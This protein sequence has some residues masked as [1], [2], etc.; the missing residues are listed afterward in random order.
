MRSTRNRGFPATASASISARCSGEA[1]CAAGL[2]GCARAGRKRTVTPKRSASVSAATRWP[3]CT[4]SNEPPNSASTLLGAGSGRGGRA[5]AV[6]SGRLGI[7]LPQVG[8]G[9]LEL[10]G[11]ADRSIAVPQAPQRLRHLVEFERRHRQVAD[12]EIALRQEVADLRHL[13]LPG[14]EL[15]LHP[16]EAE[17]GV[18]EVAAAELRHRLGALRLGALHRRPYLEGVV[19]RAAQDA[20]DQP[21]GAHSPHSCWGGAAPGASALPSALI[22]CCARTVILSPGFPPA[23][24]CW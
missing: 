11:I 17:E 2:S 15:E 18:A 1:A 24:A 22:F 12:L 5:A 6:E 4:G 3:T 19:T 14:A 20:A 16:L 13:G 9:F 21:P 23:I 10:L 8:A 7:I